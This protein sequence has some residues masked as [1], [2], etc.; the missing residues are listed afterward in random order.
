MSCCVY[1]SDGGDNKENQ[2][3]CSFE[4]LCGVFLCRAL[5]NLYLK[6]LPLDG[7]L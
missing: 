6:S 4:S 5:L 2:N 3:A 7:F 1:G